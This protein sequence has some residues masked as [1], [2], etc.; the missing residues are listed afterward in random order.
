MLGVLLHT[1]HR[2][3]FQL[4]LFTMHM[5]KSMLPSRV[6]VGPLCRWMVAGPEISRMIQEFESISD[7]I[8]QSNSRHHEQVPSLQTSLAKEV[9]SL[10][11][12]FEEYGNPFQE[13][14]GELVVLDTKDVIPSDVVKSVREVL[15]IG[16]R[17]CDNFIETRF[18]QRTTPITE[19]ITTNKLTLFSTPKTKGVSK[20]KI[21]LAALKNDCSLFSRLYI[22]CQSRDGKLEQFL[23]NEHGGYYMEG[24]VDEIHKMDTHGRSDLYA[25]L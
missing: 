9:R 10:V 23:F 4:L 5:S 13:D 3:H 12:T 1:K 14:S 17:Q 19:P 2:M 7:T 25:T 20:G 16:R 8:P 15:S 18:V 22:A 6:M 24:S 11:S 21:Q